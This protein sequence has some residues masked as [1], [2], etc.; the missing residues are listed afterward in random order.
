MKH[1][2]L[3]LLCILSICVLFNGCGKDKIQYKDTYV[4]GQDFQYMYYGETYEFG[5]SMAETDDAYYKLLDD[6][7]YYVDNHE[8]RSFV[9]K[10]RLYA[11]KG[12]LLS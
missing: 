6:Y 5:L 11:R 4:P 9:W 1:K 7:I 2:T 10:I 12:K 8:S 3:C